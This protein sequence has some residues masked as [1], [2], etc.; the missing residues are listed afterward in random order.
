MCTV[1]AVKPYVWSTTFCRSSM[2]SRNNRWESEYVAIASPVDSILRLYPTSHGV[3]RHVL[4]LAVMSVLCD[5][6]N[7]MARLKK[8]KS[9]ALDP[10]LLERLDAWL[11]KQEF[12]PSQTVVFETALREFLDKREKKDK[13]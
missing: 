12:P 8:P 13:R 5:A 6:M 4:T 3:S 11:A 9:L 1:R 10:A 7:T 2:F